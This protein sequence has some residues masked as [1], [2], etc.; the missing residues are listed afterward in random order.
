MTAHIDVRG[1]YPIYTKGQLAVKLPHE[2]PRGI[3]VEEF[4]AIDNL[5]KRIIEAKS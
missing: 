4:E 1:P 5:A 2:T 3:T